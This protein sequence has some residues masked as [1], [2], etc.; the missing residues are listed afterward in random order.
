MVSF[1]NKDVLFLKFVDSEDAKWVLEGGRRSFNGFPMQLE[2]WNPVGSV[3][4]KEMVK[5]AWI[6]R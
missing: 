3:K 1:L 5:E 2:W 4:K 6:C